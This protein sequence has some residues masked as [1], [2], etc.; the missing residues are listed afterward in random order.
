M[1][2]LAIRYPILFE[3]LLLLMAGCVPTQTRKATE[4]ETTVVRENTGFTSESAFFCKLRVTDQ[5]DK[6]R[7]YLQVELKRGYE[8]IGV[9]KFVNRFAGSY[10]LLPDYNRRDY[11]GTGSIFLTKETVRL[12]DEQVFLIAFEVPKPGNAPAALLMTEISDLQTRQKAGDE[13]MVLF[14]AERLSDRLLFF[15]KHATSPLMTGFVKTGDTLQLRGT[16]PDQAT[17]L[18]VLRLP[19]DFEAAFSPLNTKA[20]YKDPRSFKPDSV[21]TISIGQPFSFRSPGL[22]FF[23]QDSTFNNG[24]SLL[25]T[26][27]RY[28]RMT[29]AEELLKPLVYI[30][31]NDEIIEARTTTQPKQTLDRYWLRLASSNEERA[32]RSI[33][34]YYRRVSQA[35]QLFT[36]FKE[37]WKTDFGMVFIVFGPPDRITRLKDRQVWTYTGNPN[38]SEINFTFFKRPNPLSEQHYELQ[39]YA[40]YEPIWYPMVEEWRDGGID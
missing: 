24:I 22:Y 5:G 19:A 1:R 23:S 36:T 27:I 13:A 32:K 8:V 6:I 20:Q 15:N 31:S 39:R 7:V 30:S 10:V 34:L 2:N 25:V 12:T 4:S 33:K 16:P 28:P 3:A 26:G 17:T 38:F 37:G 40:E 11:L 14:S 35:N 9:D 18:K 29:R 21:F